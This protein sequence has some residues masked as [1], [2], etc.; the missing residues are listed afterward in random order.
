MSTPQ[1]P[2]LHADTGLDGLASFDRP[3]FLGS[4]TAV[5]PCVGERSSR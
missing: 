1:N 3:C 5:L 2:L 4:Y